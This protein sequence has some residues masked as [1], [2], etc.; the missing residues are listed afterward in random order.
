[1]TQQPTSL[2]E[3]PAFRDSS[4]YQRPRWFVSWVGLLVGLAIGL[5]GGLY[6]AW[7]LFP[8]IETNTR[9][10]QLRPDDK[11]QYIVAIT[12]S[13]AYD[14]DLNAVIQRLN[15]LDLG[16]DPIQAVADTACDLARSGYID[17][18]SGLRAVRSMQTFY[19]LQGKRSCAD[20]IIPDVQDPQIIQVTV[21]TETPTLPPP[22]TKTPAAIPTPTSANVVVVPTSPPQRRYEGVV[23]DTFCDTQL[24][25]IIEVYVQER[26]TQRGIGGEPVRVRWDDGESVFVTGMKP[27]RS[28][29]Y[30]DF[31]MEAGVSYTIAMPERSD[32]ASGNIVAEPCFTETGDEAISSYRVSFLRG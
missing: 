26:G 5:G 3:Q 16:G 21:P 28:V 25:G 31:Q 4:K 22:P 10:D 1:M 29:G 27:E 7:G 2:P 13:Y 14:G 12:L 30:A 18:T 20:T 23:F 9:P 6:I 11:A 32:P 19:R 8:V 17:S 15:Q 24:S